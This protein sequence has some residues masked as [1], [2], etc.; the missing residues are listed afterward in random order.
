MRQD[1]AANAMVD[2]IDQTQQAFGA[3]HKNVTDVQPEPH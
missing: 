1:F 3:G 2:L